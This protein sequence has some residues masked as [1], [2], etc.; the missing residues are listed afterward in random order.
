ME[1]GRIV[2]IILIIVGVVLTA[3]VGAFFLMGIYAVRHVDYTKTAG[4]MCAD[5]TSNVVPTDEK[6][7]QYA[8][9]VAALIITGKP[10]GTC[11]GSVDSIKRVLMV[12]DGLYQTIGEMIMEN[13]L[14]DKIEYVGE[15]AKYFDQSIVAFVKAVMHLWTHRFTKWQIMKIPICVLG[16]ILV[17]IPV[18]KSYGPKI[19]NSIYKDLINT[20]IA[21]GYIT[22]ILRYGDAYPFQIYPDVA[23]YIPQYADFLAP[24]DFVSRVLDSRLFPANITSFYEGFL[25]L[26][27]TIPTKTD[28]D[29]RIYNEL[30]KVVDEVHSATP[31]RVQ[32]VWRDPTGYTPTIVHDNKIAF[33]D[34][35]VDYVD[36]LKSGQPRDVK[37]GF[38]RHPYL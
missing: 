35:W 19:V 1:I 5:V 30:K 6:K 26:Y 28:A 34:E 7:K 8:S 38:S 20:D 31:D 18:D 13:G 16:R 36:A 14:G 25:A 10:I 27:E 4:E 17:G 15:F 11:G 23:A 29:K 37:S 33:R 24:K 12:H 2:I 9:A 21:M 22:E 32:I 3:V